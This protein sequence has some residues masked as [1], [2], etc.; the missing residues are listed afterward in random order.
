MAGNAR[1]AALRA[2]TEQRRQ[3][4][5]LATALDKALDG[6]DARD[7]ALAT[8]LC[9]GVEQHKRLLDF[10][11]QSKSS[12][13]LSKVQP[14]VLDSL[15]LAV[16][17][18][19]ASDSI[20]VSAAV[21]EAVKQ[22]KKS[23]GPR[24]AGYANALLRALAN[25]DW[26]LPPREPFDSFLAVRYS[27]PDWLAARF[28]AQLGEPEAEALC[29]CM[30][31]PPPVTLNFNP[32]RTDKE[33]LR[34]ALVDMGLEPRD[35]ALWPHCIQLAGAARLDDIPQWR[36]G[37]VWVADPAASLAV[38]AAQPQ[39]GMVVLDACAAPGGKTLACAAHLNGQ[40]SITAC[41]IAPR[42]VDDLKVAVA[43]AGYAHVD[44]QTRDAGVFEPAWQDAFDLV[45]ADLPCSGLGV[46]AKKPDIRNRT[47][48]EIAHLPALQLS[49]LDNLC[50][51][52]KPGGRLLYITCT[53][54]VEE[55]EGVADAFSQTHDD[56]SRL[57]W[58]TLWPHRHQTDGFFY[59]LWEKKQ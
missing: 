27:L 23:A 57:A 22:I 51:Y 50:R 20:P 33:A 36:S 12:L 30:N 7:A 48:A 9:N 56:Y 34:A 10:F 35:H 29:A 46:L 55:N 2:L 37:E 41:D 39:P 59:A 45:I 16:Y 38:A 5:W 24:A 49:L 3:G 28:V 43:R 11:V 13:P 32:H 6:L 14:Q 54:L 42:R 58:N 18:L 1:T 21:N 8:W 31:T 47:E 53:L 40:G 25:S 17:Q 4:V 52:V 44:V 26:A 19:W 15:R